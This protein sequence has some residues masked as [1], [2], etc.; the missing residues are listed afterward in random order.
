MRS[1]HLPKMTQKKNV[2]EFSLQGQYLT[3]HSKSVRKCQGTPAVTGKILNGFFFFG[4]MY[5]N[6]VKIT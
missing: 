1:Q 6:S 3:L 2:S 4:Y 5:Q